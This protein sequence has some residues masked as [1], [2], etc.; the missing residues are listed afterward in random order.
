MC[1]QLRGEG[2]KLPKIVRGPLN[3][4]NTEILILWNTETSDIPGVSLGC[5]SMSINR[6]SG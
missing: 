6:T 3:K 2:E 5:R 4:E 1:W